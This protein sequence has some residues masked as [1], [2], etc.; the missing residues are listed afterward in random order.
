MYLGTV[1]A[2]QV[3]FA[4][5]PILPPVTA[6]SARVYRL[7]NIRAN[8]NGL[9]GGLLNGITQLLASVA[10][11]GS[12]SLPIN[13][14][15][16][17]AGFIQPGLSTA[18]SGAGTNFLQ[19]NSVSTANTALLR[20]TENFG[21]AFKTRVAP[22]GVNTNGQTG[23][24]TALQNIPGTI[25][26]SESG[27][28]IPVTAFGTLGGVVTSVVQVGLADY[29]TRLK[30][31]FSNVPTGVNLFVTV[32]NV[33]ALSGTGSAT[34]VQ[35]AGNSVSSFA[36]LVNGET[37]PDGNGNV[38]ALAPTN[39]ANGNTTAIAAV[40]ISGGTG[41]AVWEVINTNPAALETFSFGVYT[42]Y[43]ANQNQGIPATGTVNV[44]QSYAP[45]PPA[46]SAAAGS[47]FAD[48]ADPAVRR[49]LHGSRAADDQPLPDAAALPVR[50]SPAGL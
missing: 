21:T 7:T 30:A 45:T 1:A 27:F 39:S 28:I 33:T 25:Y 41:T 17:I 43:T 24:P 13:N 35:P 46:F 6:G 38:P 19:C 44:N 22:I 32:T 10:I 40:P 3:T 4:G 12:T 49:H 14:P 36:V 42:S 5:I 18:V 23:A 11:S 34:G 47:A 50:D 8:V 20:F 15:T 16:V 31:V 29:G 9:G 26:N 2:N 48:A 37:T